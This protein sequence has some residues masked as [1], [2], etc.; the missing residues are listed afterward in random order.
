MDRVPINQ[1]WWQLTSYKED[2]ENQ[3]RIRC[4][5]ESEIGFCLVRVQ[6]DLLKYILTSDFISHNMLKP[7]ITF[8]F[9]DGVFLFCHPVKLQASW[10]TMKAY[11]IMLTNT[12]FLCSWNA[13]YESLLGSNKPFAQPI[14]LHVRSNAFHLT[15]IMQW[16]TAS[17]LIVELQEMVDFLVDIWEQEGLYD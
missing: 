15:I 11:S 6:L 12:K 5:F 9:S 2:A 14:P 10:C 3:L 8:F 7:S 4:K 13:A 1:I 17:T 16:H